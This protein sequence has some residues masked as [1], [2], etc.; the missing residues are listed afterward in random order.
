MEK[1]NLNILF[2]QF[3]NYDNWN[4]FEYMNETII[5]WIHKIKNSNVMWLLLGILIPNAE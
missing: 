4:T 5:W 2:P 3:I 1:T